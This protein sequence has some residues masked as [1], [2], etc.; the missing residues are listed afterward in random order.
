[1][2]GH[3]HKPVTNDGT[4]GGHENIQ[5]VEGRTDYLD[6]DAKSRHSIWGSINKSPK[7]GIHS[8]P[9]VY[10][11]SLMPRLLSTVITD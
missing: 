9:A 4:M 5:G 7:N 6:T 3:L 10:I 8:P 1:M 2:A 11:Y